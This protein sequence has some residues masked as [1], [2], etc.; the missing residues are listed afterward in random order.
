MQVITAPETVFASEPSPC[1]FLAGSI[2]MGSAVEWQQRVIREL[3]DIL[4]GTILNPRRL[5]WDSSWKQEIT[6]PQFN[7]QV[8][9]EL[10]G[11][12]FADIVVFYFDPAT[13]S[14]V[15][16]MELGLMAATDKSLIV[17]CPEG[18]WRKG[19]VDIICQRHNIPQVSS[20]D[21]LIIYLREDLMN[22]E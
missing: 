11:L 14:P 10:N 20:L 7:E 12:D 8:T 1:V 21:E 2:E 16:M 5:D 3:S 6:N 19:N 15:T 18:F 13:K 4:E 17:C 9:W 22:M